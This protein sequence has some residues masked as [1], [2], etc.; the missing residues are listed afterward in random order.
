M[1]DTC[2]EV[3]FNGSMETATPTNT[4]Q[5]LGTH[6][7]NNGQYKVI[8]RQGSRVVHVDRLTADDAAAF[9]PAEAQ[10]AWERMVRPGVARVDCVVS[11]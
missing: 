11:A 1:L 5:I 10:A 8:A 6:P 2:A 7:S 9:G 4:W 3:C